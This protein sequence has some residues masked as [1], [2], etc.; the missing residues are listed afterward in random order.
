MKSL[1]K[2]N[3][4]N[5]TRK[6]RRQDLQPHTGVKILP[7]G[8]KLYGSKSHSGDEILEYTKQNSVRQGKPCISENISWF[9][10][11]ARARF[12]HNLYF[13]KGNFNQKMNT[14]TLSKSAKLM[15]ISSNNQSFFERLYTT[16]NLK[17]ETCL[18]ISKE[19]W[20]K[21]YDH[22]Y[23]SMTK[24]ERALHEFKFIYG[25]L[26]LKEQYDF[27]L[28][29]R[30][31]IN[32]NMLPHKNMILLKHIDLIIQYYRLRKSNSKNNHLGVYSFEKIILKNVCRLFHENGYSNISGIFVPQQK[33]FW[34]PFSNFINNVEEIVLFN[35]HDVLE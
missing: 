5:T 23:L 28:F 35:P 9:G 29:L 18:S 33:S 27:L 16:S 14:W 13:L 12:E 7:K 25:Y 34:I 31:L 4:N 19:E 20:I 11:Y 26:S 17:L 15:V 2:K 10:D 3:R 8:Y 30:F 32:H 21:K 22:P 6:K 24:N 1:K